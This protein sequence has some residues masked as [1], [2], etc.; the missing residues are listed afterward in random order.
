[1]YILYIL[2][3]LYIHVHIIHTCTSFLLLINIY[4]KMVK[5]YIF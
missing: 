2:Y 5:P 1:M 3:I 4:V